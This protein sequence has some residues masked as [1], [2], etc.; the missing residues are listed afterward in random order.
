[1]NTKLLKTGDEAPLFCL[2][3]KENNIICLKQFRGKWVV[4][5][6]YPKDNTKGCTL[7]G[8]D[9]SKS[10]KDFTKNS[11]VIVGIS[12]DTPECHQKFVKKH[13][14]TVT[15]LSDPEHELIEMY[16]AWQ[17]K[18]SYGREY[19]GV[20]RSTFLINPEGVIEYIWR[21]VKVDGHVR[22]V[23]QKLHDIQ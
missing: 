10:L 8:I 12:P 13:S 18:K 17:L 20:E 2:P 23:F 14:L 7:E 11:A 21:K 5:Y 9:F 1:M 6:F 16:N 3:D 22:D 4:L 15:L 19:F